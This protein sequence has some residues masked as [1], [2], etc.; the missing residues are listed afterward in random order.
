MD[1]LGAM[2]LVTLG[3]PGGRV[4]PPIHS[5]APEVLSMVA[6]MGPLPHNSISYPQL[7]LTVILWCHLLEHGGGIMYL[8]RGFGF[9]AK[10]KDR[11]V[12]LVS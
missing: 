11:V 8:L 2:A 10:D 7:C 3:L 6:S 5:W 9:W 1:L 4:P 12:G